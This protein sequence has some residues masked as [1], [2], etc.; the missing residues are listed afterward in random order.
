M[1]FIFWKCL[2]LKK[3]HVLWKKKLQKY[4][5]KHSKCYLGL[6]TIFFGNTSKRFCQND[7]SLVPSKLPD[8]KVFCKLSQTKSIL[9][10]LIIS[11]LILLGSRRT[12]TF[13]QTVCLPHLSFYKG[14]FDEKMLSELSIKLFSYNNKNKT[15]RLSVPC[16]S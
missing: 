8:L 12:Q 13:Y 10:P 4:V 7:S 14:I 9:L 2:L 6:G 3:L 11:L 16:D 5:S 1:F 15:E